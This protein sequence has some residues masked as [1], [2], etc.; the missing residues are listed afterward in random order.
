MQ[1][2]CVICYESLKLNDSEKNYAM[3]D[4]H[5]EGILNTLKVWQHYLLRRKFELCI[6]HMSLKY[7]FNQLNLNS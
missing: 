7:F 6:D 4:L 2:D 1:D 3:H 5:L